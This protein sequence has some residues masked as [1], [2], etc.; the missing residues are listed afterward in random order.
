MRRVI[1][2]RIETH[3]FFYKQATNEGRYHLALNHMREILGYTKILEDRDN[4]K[5]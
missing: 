5:A 1:L 2:R 3:Y 4:G